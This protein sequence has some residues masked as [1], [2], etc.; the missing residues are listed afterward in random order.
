MSIIVRHGMMSLEEF[1]FWLPPP[2]V[3]QEGEEDDV[4][5]PNGSGDSESGTV[6]RKVV[7]GTIGQGSARK[8]KGSNG[9]ATGSKRCTKCKEVRSTKDYRPHDS[10]ADGLAAYCRFCQNGLNKSYR[11]KNAPM[12]VK[13]HFATRIADQY[14]GSQ[15]LPEGYTEKLESY[16]GYKMSALIKHLDQTLQE[17]Y[18]EEKDTLSVLKKGWH[19]DHIK[20]LKLF[21]TKVI[22]DTEFRKCWDLKNLKVIP[23]EDNLAKGSSF[24]VDIEE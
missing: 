5:T 16:L 22:G 3:P 17:E 4:N 18:P 6:Q 20:P 23:A 2:F 1:N 11:D 21:P 8:N 24:N 14:K 13:H 12:R 7:K 15:N 10:T 9:V 19:I